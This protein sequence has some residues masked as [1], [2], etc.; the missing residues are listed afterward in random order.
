LAVR[1]ASGNYLTDIVH[2]DVTFERLH[3]RALF[4]DL[5]NRAGFSY[6]RTAQTG[7]FAQ[8]E[9]FRAT[10]LVGQGP[11]I[12]ARWGASLLELFGW[13]ADAAWCRQIIDKIRSGS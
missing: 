12:A 10:D 3:G 6:P 4:M 7:R 11:D 2:V 5:P 1:L 9:E 8:S 13:D